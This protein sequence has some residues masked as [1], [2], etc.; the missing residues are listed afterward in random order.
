M[1]SGGNA[2]PPSRF[3]IPA[4]KGSSAPWRSRRSGAGGDRVGVLVDPHV[5]LRIG[6]GAEH[7][8]GGGLAAALVAARRLRR[9]QA[10]HQT[11]FQGLPPV[12]RNDSAMAESTSPPSACCPA[13]RNPGR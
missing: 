6:F 4:M 1:T 8:Q 9:L 2:L 11:V 7:D 5:E 10:S 3:G 12:S 13:P